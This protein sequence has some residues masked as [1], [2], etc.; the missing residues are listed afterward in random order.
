MCANAVKNNGNFLFIN[1]IDRA[2]KYQHMP[3]IYIKIQNS[4]LN[5]VIIKKK[6]N[7]KTYHILILYYNNNLS[8]YKISRWICQIVSY[9]VQ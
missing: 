2:I 6:I 9:V 4:I 3:A 5:N 7:F 8:I 1:D